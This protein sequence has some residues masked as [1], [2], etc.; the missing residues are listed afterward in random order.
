[1]HQHDICIASNPFQPTFEKQEKWLTFEVGQF[2][3]V[4]ACVVSAG[5]VVLPGSPVLT[6]L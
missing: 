4:L 1:V 2:A 3:V 6:F 5:L